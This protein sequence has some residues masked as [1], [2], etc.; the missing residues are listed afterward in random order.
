MSLLRVGGFTSFS[1]SD[2][3]DHLAAVVFC[4]GCPWRCR[5]CHNPHL[6]PTSRLGE[7]DWDAVL[8]VLSRRRGRLDAVV[9]SGGEPTLQA[10]LG[11]AMDQVRALGFKV[12]LHTAGIYPERLEAVLS[13]LDWVGL[14]LK[15]P[16][17]DYEKTTRVPRSGG[18]VRES[19]ALLTRR[20]VEHELRCTWHPE[21]LSPE[22]LARL[23]DEIRDLTTAKLVLQEYRSLGCVE[24]LPELYGE[25]TRRLLAELPD[26][27]DRLRLR[28]D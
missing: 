20:G 10:E 18:P 27:T 11:A 5:Y 12:G 13:R 19:L 25:A 7:L 4:Q 6:Q 24:P 2:F 28:A 8:E 3:P 17:L 15:A 1:A 26:H 9:F 23:L 14:D 22:D 16:F 21:L